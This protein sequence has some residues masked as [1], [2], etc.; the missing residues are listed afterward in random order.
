MV[1]TSARTR[2]AG[3]R[4]PAE[5]IGHA[6]WLY[7]RFPLGLRMVE[8]LLAARGIIVSHE[9]V[10][11]W[12]R[13]FGQPFANQIRRPLPRVGDKWHLDEV[14]LKIA[15]AKHWLWRAVDQTGI[16]L[17]VLVQRRR[18]K[19]AAK[20][21]LRKLLKKQ[22]R[23]P[24][25]MITD[26]LASYGASKREVMPGI[27]HRQHKGL[28]NR[29]ENSHQPTRRRERQMKQFKSAGQAQRFLSAQVVSAFAPV[30][31]RRFGHP[32]ARSGG[33]QDAE[34]YHGSAHVLPT[35]RCRGNTLAHAGPAGQEVSGVVVAAAIS[36]R[37]SSALQSKH[38]ST[39]ALDAAVILLKSV[40]QIATCPM[41]HMAAELGP[42]CPGIGIVA[43][44]GDAIRGDAG[45]RL[46]RSKEGLGGGKVAVLT[47]HHVDQG[48]SAI[49]R[50]IQI[51]PTTTHPNVCL[52][53][54]PASADFAFSSPT[55]VLSQCWGEFGFPIT[56]GL[57]A[58]DEPADQEHLGQVP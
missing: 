20:R 47:Q 30:D 16:V 56:D 53:D 5:I 19:H 48:A 4:F 46:C 18:D 33:L 52:V 49:D 42:D 55:Q 39:S 9:T 26:K 15:G 40:V 25:V 14:V 57:I 17:D 37:R 11:Q 6:V 27:E 21:L 2:Y 8:E 50:A 31:R 7:F 23:P 43:I 44:G 54:V 41:P 36:P 22:M 29:A 1:R 3:Y 28:N 10:R 35:P 12:A 45:H 13:K 58:E 38:R 24:R 51:P 32:A 34:R